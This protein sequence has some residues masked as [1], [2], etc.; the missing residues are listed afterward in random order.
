[1]SLKPQYLTKE[2]LELRH[3][4]LKTIRLLI[5][6]D[7]LVGVKMFK[8]KLLSNLILHTLADSAN[9][10]NPKVLSET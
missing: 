5:E 6:S 10:D 9:Q 3:Q 7:A 4:A 2:T 1:M 8:L